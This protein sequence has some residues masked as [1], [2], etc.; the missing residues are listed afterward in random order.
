MVLLLRDSP[1]QKRNDNA[2]VKILS[3]INKE[4]ITLFTGS[5]PKGGPIRCKITLNSNEEVGFV[6][7]EAY[8]LVGGS[9]VYMPLFEDFVA[10]IRG[11]RNRMR[12]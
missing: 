5:A 11:D 2:R 1:N 10:Q 12:I 8:I 9:K 4:D 6:T 3:K 7:N